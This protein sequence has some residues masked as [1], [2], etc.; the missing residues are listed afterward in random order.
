MMRCKYKLIY[1]FIFFCIFLTYPKYLNA[2]NGPHDDYE[3]PEYRF[4]HQQQQALLSVRS[5]KNTFIITF[6]TSL[7]NLINSESIGTKKEDLLVESLKSINALIDFP[8]ES[9]CSLV[10]AKAD[11]FKKHRSTKEDLH[12]LKKNER[13][14]YIEPFIELIVSYKV[15]CKNSIKG[16]E[17][18]LHILK[19]WPDLKRLKVLANSKRPSFAKDGEIIEKDLKLGF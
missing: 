4:E 7:Q 6:K 11:R 14:K 15:S 13:G 5:L 19:K 17:I 1:T 2:H 18:G 3:P 10:Y 8:K 16:Q 9:T 12:K